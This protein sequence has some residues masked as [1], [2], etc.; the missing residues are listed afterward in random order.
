[1]KKIAIFL[2]I[3]TVIFGFDF[4]KTKFLEPK[5]AFKPSISIK[6]NTIIAKIVLG[7]DI[8]IYKDKTS[9][10]IT[11]KDIKA[12]AETV[13]TYFFLFSK[14]YAANKLNVK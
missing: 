12:E 1:M 6:N 14:W 13:L 3:F 2:L 7:K 11:G 9:L 8:Y 5:D 10:S 4:P